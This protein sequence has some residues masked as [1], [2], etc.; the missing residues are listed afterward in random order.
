M[1]SMGDPL[2]VGV[3]E[4]SGADAQAPGN[5][6]SAYRKWLRFYLDFCAK[7]RGGKYTAEESLEPFLESLRS[8]RH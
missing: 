1:V 2:S 5:E 3:G 8:K 6:H 4:E 7:Y